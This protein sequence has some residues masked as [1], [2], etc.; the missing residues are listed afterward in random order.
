MKLILLEDVVEGA[1]LRKGPARLR[2]T[3]YFVTE[4]ENHTSPFTSV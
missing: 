1:R 4:G 2:I 3:L